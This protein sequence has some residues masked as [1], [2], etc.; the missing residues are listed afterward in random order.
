M[1]DD[2]FVASE[3]FVAG[4]EGYEHVSDSVFDSGQPQSALWIGGVIVNIEE[5]EGLT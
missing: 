3:S 2:T 4:C 1:D 5:T